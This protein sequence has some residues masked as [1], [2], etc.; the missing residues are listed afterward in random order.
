MILFGAATLS[1]MTL[2]IMTFSKMTLNITIISMMTFSIKILSKTI[3]NVTLRIMI[4]AIIIK[5]R[6]TQYKSC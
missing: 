2:S 5:K 4:Y 6:G 1:T 3:K